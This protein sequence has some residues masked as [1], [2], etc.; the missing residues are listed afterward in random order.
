MTNYIECTR[1]V[2][3]QLS[4]T[5]LADKD[6][7]L[8]EARKNLIAAERMFDLRLR[9]SFPSVIPKIEKQHAQYYILKHL[10]EH[11]RKLEHEGEIDPKH[12]E[13][14]A[15]EIDQKIWEL[16]VIP[17]I[18]SVS[19]GEQL[20]ISVLS[21][22]FVRYPNEWNGDDEQ[23][24]ADLIKTGIHILVKPNSVILA[25]DHVVEFPDIASLDAR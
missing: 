11:Y 2:I 15:A 6:E 5:D 1:H 21:E 3:E 19:T 7:V 18:S 22:L 14:I 23:E 20:N 10:R 8:R 9:A 13:I 17:K 16:K 4:H 25:D 12:A 24:L